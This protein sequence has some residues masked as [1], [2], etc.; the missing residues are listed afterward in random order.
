MNKLVATFKKIAMAA[1]AFGTAALCATSVHAGGFDGKPLATNDWFDVGFTNDDVGQLTG[2]T[3]IPTGKGSWTHIPSGGAEVV[4]D[5]GYCLIIDTD[6]NDPLTLTPAALPNTV[7]NETISVEVLATP[8][9]DELE[10]PTDSPISAFALRDD[11]SAITPVAYVAGGWTNLVYSPGAEHLTNAWFTLYTD[12]A[13]VGDTKYLRFSIKP[14]NGT[15]TIPANGTPTILEDSTGET[16]F[17]AAT[18]ATNIS[19]VSLTGST[20][21]RTISGDALFDAVASANGTNYA[22]FAEAISAAGGTY[23]IIVLDNAAAVPAGWKIADGKLV[24]IVYVAQII[25]NDEPGQ[26]YETI[27]EAIN[28]ASAGDTINVLASHTVDS[29]I[30]VNKSVTIAGAGKNATTVSFNTPANTKGFSIGAS[31]V[32]IKDMTIYQTTTANTTGHIAIEK[33][34]SVNGICVSHSDITL[35]GLNFTNGHTA[36]YV[37]G[38][39]VT[40]E[41]CEFNVNGYGMDIYSLRGN[42]C[43]K[44][45]LFNMPSSV[46]TAAMYY[47]DTSGTIDHENY[48][49]T[50]TLVITGNT[51]EDHGVAG[52]AIQCFFEFTPSAAGFV[53]DL[54]LTFTSNVVKRATNKAIVFGNAA[55]LSN[56]FSSI[57]INYNAFIDTASGRQVL[58]RDDAD[59]SG[60]TIDATYNYWGSNDPDFTKL[61]KANV[62]GQQINTDYEPYYITYTADP[63]SLSDLR[64]LPLVAQIIR[65]NGATTNKFEA[66]AAAITAAQDGDTIELLSNVV[67]DGTGSYYWLNAAGSVTIDGKGFTLSAPAT[68]GPTDSAIMLGDSSS[69]GSPS[70]YTITNMTFSGFDS[71]DHSVVRCQGATANILDCTF[72]NNTISGFAWGVVSG[73]NGTALSVKNCVFSGNTATKC[74]NIGFNVSSGCSLDVENCRFVDNTITDAGVIYVA[75][76]VAS[77]TMH[78]STFSNNTISASGAAVVYCSGT[79][80]ITGNL[81]TDNR[82]TSTGKEGVIVLGSG[83]TGTVVSNNAF[84]DNMLGTTA[85]HYATI[86]TGADCDISGNY[87]GDGAAAEIEDHKDVYDSGTHTIANTT[88]ATA[89][90][91]NE[92]GNGVTVTL[93]VP[94]VA[95]IGTTEYHSLAE[96]IAAVADGQTIVVVADIAVTGWVE[97]KKPGIAFTIDTNG[98]TIERTNGSIFD[99]YSAV[100]FTNSVDGVGKIKA[101]GRVLYCNEG[102]DCTLESGSVI[103]GTEGNVINVIGDYGS[104]KTLSKFTMNGGSVTGAD[105]INIQGNKYGAEFIM[106]GGSITSDD[107]GIEAHGIHTDTFGGAKITINGGTINA[108]GEGAIN[109]N[110]THDGTVLVINGGT[111]TCTGEAGIYQSHAY[112]TITNGVITGREAIVVKGGTLD[113]SGGVF[114]ATG[115]AN[116]PVVAGSSGYAEGGTGDALYIEDNYGHSDYAFV[117]TVRVNVTGGTFISQNANAV[118]A[119][120]ADGSADVA[121]ADVAISGGSFKCAT[122]KSVI[123]TSESFEGTIVASGGIYSERP[124]DTFVAENYAVVANNEAE[125]KDVY[126]WKVAVVPEG[127]SAGEGVDVQES[128]GSTSNVVLTATEANYLNAILENNTNG[129]DK[130]A[131]DDIL[132][133][134]TVEEFKE[135]VLLNIDITEM[136]SPT[137][138][139][140]DFNITAIKRFRDSGQQKVKVTVKLDRHG[141]EVSQPI[142]GVLQLKTSPDGKD[143]NWRVLSEVEISD[144]NFSEGSES[145]FILSAEGADHI[146]KATVVERPSASNN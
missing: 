13:T 126:P 66:L 111:I 103:I 64:P 127:Y 100:T 79:T 24:Q 62:S 17:P 70:V 82:V 88:F 3:G 46:K 94:P 107:C 50:G 55:D 131:V 34:S 142:N 45:N 10:D 51:Y 104:A 4:S 42:S 12:F 138:A 143:G 23:D 39:N 122:G 132:E 123:Y 49:S 96:A 110:G 8:S 101:H 117:H 58:R 19:S 145:D 72:T 105:A 133:S 68:G 91:L 14:A 22:T 59:T 43:I 52:V 15:P 21:C 77:A 113:V 95:K 36:I 114:I 90:A 83:S 41:G 5:S 56:A 115:A 25:H 87:W 48:D 18:N 141:S 71:G 106:N 99:I 124:V 86:Y 134:M 84:V 80:A 76:G 135:A 93:Y 121:P 32:T 54:D 31:N 109:I 144:D 61:I 74:V 26:Q 33:G 16:W 7:S 97:I 81:F 27:Q 20:S 44:N 38:E 128:I 69:S 30:N 28:A 102:A 140:P 119:R 85:S 53:K 47:D 63:F 2:T 89:Y 37:A 73:E 125:T 139:K 112:V 60:L 11:G 137:Y 146:F 120:F 40:V 118:S 136:S 98:K 78:N 35:S 6:G 57:K 65:D 92:S 75:G 1:V 130:A 108:N 9:T 129:C 67:W 29:T 116:D